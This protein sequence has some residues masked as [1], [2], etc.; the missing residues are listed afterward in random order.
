MPYIYDSEHVSVHEE[1]YLT[2]G[3]LVTYGSVIAGKNQSIGIIIGVDT[4]NFGIGECTFLV[5]SNGQV[6][7]TSFV[8]LVNT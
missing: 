3:S 1:K 7:R 2:I 5:Y 8:L 4:Y 6:V